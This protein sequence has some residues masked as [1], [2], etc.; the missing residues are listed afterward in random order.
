MLA[1]RPVGT[2]TYGV[3]AQAPRADVI[4][5]TP[6]D[7]TTV[8]VANGSAWYFNSNQSWG[9]SGQVIRQ[10]RIA[11]TLEEPISPTRKTVL[12][13]E[14]GQSEQRVALWSQ[15]RPFHTAWQRV[16]LHRD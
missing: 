10:I 6:V 14:W 15:R 5:P 12:A 1:C 16:V 9:S 7:T 13:Y 3:L 11:V 4:F 8:H 2:N